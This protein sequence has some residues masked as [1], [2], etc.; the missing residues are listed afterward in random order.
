MFDII[1][2]KNS[3]AKNNEVKIIAITGGFGSG[4]STVAGFYEKQGY[5]VIN[6]DL[7]AKD[8]MTN[9][10]IVKVELVKVFGNKILNENGEIIFQHLSKLAFDNN[11]KSKDNLAKLNQIVHPPTIQAMINKIEEYIKDGIEIIFVESAL[12]YESALDE[13]FD[14]IIVVDAKEDV[15]MKRIKEKM[16]L[17]DEEIRN[18]MREQISTQVKVNLADFVIE[19]NTNIEKTL[20]NAAFILDL[21]KMA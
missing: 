18:R 8:I 6:T 21:I 3:E 15:R 20:D 14:Y 17:S 16:K 10:S 7:L 13:G 5:P 2:R 12:I 1:E 9:D 4:K 19:N 11:E